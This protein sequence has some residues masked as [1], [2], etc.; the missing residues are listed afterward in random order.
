MVLFKRFAGFESVGLVVFVAVHLVVL[1][2]VLVVGLR[3]RVFVFVFGVV[4]VAF[5]LVVGRGVE[6]VRRRFLVSPHGLV[7][8]GFIGRRHRLVH[9]RVLVRDQFVVFE[10]LVFRL[11]LV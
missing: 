8:A 4:L 1:G 7:H 9:G 10:Q 5:S 6:I 2:H 11:H 3:F